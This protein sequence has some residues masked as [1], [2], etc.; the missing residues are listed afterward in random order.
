MLMNF[1]TGK[2]VIY[3]KKKKKHIIYN[4]L[5]LSDE[6]ESIFTL[7]FEVRYITNQSQ[8]TKHNLLQHNFIRRLTRL[9]HLWNQGNE[10]PSK[11]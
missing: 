3:F 5:F 9:Q 11:F 6:L 10:T 2:W 1:E 4:A 8:Y 7:V